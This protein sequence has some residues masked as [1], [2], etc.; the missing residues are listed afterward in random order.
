MCCNRSNFKVIV[1]FFALSLSAIALGGTK[2]DTKPEAKVKPEHIV[3][4]IPPKVKILQTSKVFKDKYYVLKVS[5]LASDNSDVRAVKVWF[6]LNGNKRP[7]DREVF[8]AEKIKGDRWE[9]LI[10]LD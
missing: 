2:P 5:I 7:E 10:P 8:Q 3:D 4:L 1:L 6:D 9:I